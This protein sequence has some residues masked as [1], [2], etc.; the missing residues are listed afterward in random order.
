MLVDRAHPGRLGELVR[1]LLPHHAGLQVHRDARRL[2]TAERGAVV[3]LCPDADQAGWLNLERPVVSH[4]EIRLV[5][6]SDA[7]TSAALAHG[8]VDFFHWISHRIE[9][10]EGPWMPAVR[11]IRAALRARARGVAWLGGGLMETFEAALPGRPV[12]LASAALPYEQI[13]DAAR[14]A[15]RAWV[16]F[17]DA[18]T[19]LRRRRVAWALGEAG[20]RGRV[21]LVRPSRPLPGFWPAHARPRSLGVAVAKLEAAGAERPGRLAALL[22]LEPEALNL[23]EVMMRG[24]V[25]ESVLEETAAQADDGG[26]ALACLA[27]AR[28]IAMA[29]HH[30]P[31]LRAGGLVHVSHPDGGGQASKSTHARFRET[32]SD[33]GAW[34]ALVERAL[35]VDDGEVAERWARRWLERRPEDPEALC[36]LGKA[37]RA[38]GQLVAAAEVLRSSVAIYERQSAPDPVR[39]GDALNQLGRAMYYQGAYADAAR[40]AR[41]ALRLL[42]EA[43]GEAHPAS[44]AVLARLNDYVLSDEQHAE[45]ERLLEQ[46]IGI[47]NTLVGR[48]REVPPSLLLRL[49]HILVEHERYAEAED[50]LRAALKHR[51]GAQAARDRLHLSLCSELGQALLGQ[52]RYAEAESSFR[53]A[54]AGYEERGSDVPLRLASG[55]GEA[56]SMQGKY[57]QAASVLRRA[58]ERAGGRKNRPFYTTVLCTMGQIRVQQGRYVEAEPLFQEARAIEAQAGRTQSLAYI[59]ASQGLAR[60]WLHHYGRSAEAEVLLREALAAE[61]RAVGR[62]D[63]ALGELLSDLAGAIVDQGRFAE[64]EP[65]LKRALRIAESAGDRLEV[66]VLLVRLAEVQASLKRQHA[67][68]TARRALTELTRELGAEH[69]TTVDARIRLQALLER[70]G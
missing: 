9:C 55:Y 45:A 13:V 41:K 43:L 15:G 37:L 35:Q 68:D 49:G 40:S 32:S 25:S 16:A 22:D 36:A 30:A 44:V 19:P 14:P 42:R 27:A 52:E 50:L 18:D 70:P 21:V 5:L 33:P 64:A 39:Y 62:D 26:A 65:V 61:E 24:G 63:P 66:G 57:A 53:Q 31:V 60:L 69:P 48:E 23:A 1:A 7:Q 38:R 51:E 20:R 4:R 47:R 54:V 6:F 58:L 8:A 10:P 56:L 29:R 3:V 46:A 2:A 34:R 67:A 11:T 59:Q 28:G 17:T 12:S